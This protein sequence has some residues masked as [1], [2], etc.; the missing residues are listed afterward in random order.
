MTA[1]NSS[2]AL[3]IAPSASAFAFS[4]A[5]LCFVSFPMRSLAASMASVIFFNSAR[6]R[7]S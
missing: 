3:R 2:S 4:A 1:L 7:G 6:S 5:L